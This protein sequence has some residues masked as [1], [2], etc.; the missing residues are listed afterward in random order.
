MEMHASRWTLVLT[1]MASM[2]GLTGCTYEP[3]DERGVERNETL[4]S[5]SASGDADATPDEAE[6]EAGME[7]FA[8]TAKAASDANEGEIAK[9]VRALRQLGVDPADI[10]TRNVAIQRIQYGDRKGQYQASNVL[11]VTLRDVEL[12]SAA[13][14]AV[15]DAGANI[16]R[17]PDLRMSDPE[18][19]ANSAYTAA[20]KAARGRAQ[21][22]ADAADMKIARVLYIRDA[23][24]SQGGRYLQGATAID[25]AP[26]P[27]MAARTVSREAMPEE[28][29]GA[30]MPGRTT[31]SVTV[32]VDFALQ[33]K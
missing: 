18:A 27:P 5:V 7:S 4:L 14:T 11:S 16:L 13:I 21:A 6:F 26:P 31:S 28:G 2:I 3:T 23:G 17:G 29:G 32:Q 20:Y 30:I 33:P 25:I 12:A 24:G 8:A 19:A 22:Y 9:V 10:Q 1:A 15:S